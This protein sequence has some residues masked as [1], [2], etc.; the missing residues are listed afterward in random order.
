M[1]TSRLLFP[2]VN[3][4]P[5]RTNLEDILQDIL[6]NATATVFLQLYITKFKF[7]L[8]AL[9]MTCD[10]WPVTSDLQKTPA[11]KKATYSSRRGYQFHRHFVPDSSHSFGWSH[12]CAVFVAVLNL[13]YN[14]CVIAPLWR[15]SL[16]RGSTILDKIKWNSKPPFPP[17][18]GWSRAKGKNAPFFHPWF[19]EE[20][21]LDFPFILST[22][23]IL[24]KIK[25][26]NKPPSPP[27]Q[28]WSR[29][30]G[31]NALFSHPW[32][33]GG[34]GAVG[35]PFILSKIVGCFSFFSR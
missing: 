6:R 33:G 27:N 23:A 18:Q 9:S 10:L 17:S 25:W 14:T 1:T 8:P 13:W 16:P 31:K 15:N 21:G 4:C 19:G 29:A 30:K 26:N 34:G 12:I 5:Y 2:S 3:K 28:G 7:R 32:F 20:G 24:D 22:I 35:F 11:E